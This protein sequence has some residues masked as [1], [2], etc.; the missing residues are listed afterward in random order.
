LK[1]VPWAKLRILLAMT[2]MGLTLSSCQ[3]TGDASAVESERTYDLASLKTATILS[4]KNL[5]FY[6]SDN[7]DMGRV[8]G[9]AITGTPK[10]EDGTF[11][12]LALSSGGPDGAFGVGVLNGLSA[13]GKRP[14]YEVVTGISTGALIAPFA[15]AGPK[16][17]FL[18]KSLYTGKQID[19]LIGAP[20]YFRAL[21]GGALYEPENL[22]GLI[23]NLITRDLMT[24]I[25][26]LN[27]QGRRLYVATANLDADELT[28]W[29]MTKIASLGDDE[30][31]NLFRK[32]I[33]AAISIPGA[34]APVRITSMS[35]SGPIEELHGDGAVLANFYID[36]DM[37]P[38]D[39]IGVANLE[40]IIHNQLKPKP[41]AQS[42]SLVPL[43][44]KSVTSLSRSSMVLLLRQAWREA[45]A[46]GILLRYANLPPQWPSVS[47]LD[48]DR[49]YMNKTYELGYDLAS[50][51]AVWNSVEP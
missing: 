23:R 31:L 27:N 6:P 45:K 18:L 41:T 8:T 15:F 36:P 34:F 51:G 17:D 39:A 14:V 19:G 35:A 21:A 33:E 12:V 46:R 37:V 3:I 5:R 26:G 43:L 48:I 44:K 50:D 47:A 16:Y 4:R 1:R 13:S 11:D 28:V 9:W 24:E 7:Q 10:L 32:V 38:E 22:Q 49:G 2:I 30:S 42:D 20:N 25:G 40:V 29:D